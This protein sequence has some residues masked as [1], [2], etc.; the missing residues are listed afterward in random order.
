MV[1]FSL[2]FV[3]VTGI[4]REAEARP[5]F[6]DPER[7]IPCR[8][9]G[10]IEQITPVHRAPVE[11][12]RNLNSASDLFRS[13][14]VT[15]AP[16][17]HCREHLAVVENRLRVFDCGNRA[18]SLTRDSRPSLRLAS[19]QAKVFSYWRLDAQGHTGDLA[20]GPDLLILRNAVPP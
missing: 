11:S 4:L 8:F 13:S 1:A 17:M 12:Q 16:S 18:G 15:S 2:C 7:V 3:H 14:T 5:R 20:A 6:S 10:F 9:A 19:R